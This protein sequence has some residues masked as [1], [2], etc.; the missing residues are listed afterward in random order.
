[1]SRRGFDRFWGKGGGW[2]MG[3]NV[4]STFHNDAFSKYKRVRAWKY[5]LL[6]EHCAD[7][8]DEKFFS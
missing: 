4:I 1:M 7:K 8:L 2:E 5:V 3:A 6:A